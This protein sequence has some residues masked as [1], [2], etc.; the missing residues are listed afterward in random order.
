V[1]KRFWISAIAGLGLAGCCMGGGGGGAP[2]SLGPG[3]T[4]DPTTVTGQ[5][6]GV[7]DASSF[8]SGCLG[9]IGSSPNHV[10]TVTGPIPYLRIVAAAGE[11]ITLVVRR[12]DGTYLCNDDTEGLNP[13]VEGQFVPGNYDVYVGSYS[14][15]GQFASYRVGF[16]ANQATMPS[17]LPPP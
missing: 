5:A 9:H 4:P 16:S 12:P 1:D 14:S 2:V 3:F 17:S 11:D 13:M 8:G 6:G 10:L 7:V 15:E